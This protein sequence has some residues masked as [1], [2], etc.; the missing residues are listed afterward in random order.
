M[1]SAFIFSV[2]PNGLPSELE[3]R[4]K[5]AVHRIVDEGYN[6]QQVSDFLG[7]DA[8]S[9]RRWLR[10]YERNGDKGLSG[11]PASGRP[12]KLTAFQ[13]KIVARWL[14]E[15]PSSFGFHTE[16]WTASRLTQL[17]K[18]EFGIVFNSHYIVDWLRERHFTPQ[19][20]QKVP[21]KRDPIAIAYWLKHDWPRIKQ[22]AH[23]KGAFLALIDETG[24]FT[25]PLLRRSWA[26]RGHP[27]ELKLNSISKTDKVSVAAAMCINPKRDTLGLFFK[28]MINDYFD[29]FSMAAFLEA[30]LRSYKKPIIAVWD[31]GRNHTGGP[32]RDLLS[33]FPK[34]LFLEKLPPYA[35]V[36]N[37]VEFVW[38]WLKFGK[39]SNFSPKDIWD[40]DRRVVEEL[41]SICSSQTNLR[42]LFHHSELPLP[43]ALVTR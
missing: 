6:I 28:T 11:E 32:I 34:R 10:S 43:R 26:K 22:K 19:K 1:S 30:M 15:D 17:I 39:L 23:R 20:P 18:H 13:E 7:V 41:A 25:S 9:I 12:R 31:D 3:H 27:P 5:L 40:L 2:R 35:P 4:R 16:L 24:L 42:S 33:T 37:P 21:K 29:S 36:I 14:S 8:S 38:S